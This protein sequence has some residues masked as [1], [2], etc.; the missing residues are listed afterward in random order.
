M[1][2]ATHMGS[3]FYL[4]VEVGIGLAG[5]AFACMRR[6]LRATNSAQVLFV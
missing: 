5:R 2:M 6:P 4:L 3:H 1:K